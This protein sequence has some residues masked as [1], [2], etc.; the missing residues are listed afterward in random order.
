MNTLTQ[1]VVALTL[2]AIS[3]GAIAIFVYFRDKGKKLNQR[4]T[5][6]FLS[7]A[8]WSIGEAFAISAPTNAKGLLLWRINQIGVIFIPIF[9]V[10]FVFTLLEIKGKKYKL[11]PISYFIGGIFL[12]LDSTSLFVLEVVPKFSFNYFINPGR[13]YYLFIACWA[14]WVCYGLFELLRAHLVSSGAK[15][16]QL[17]YF[18]WSMLFA[19]IGGAPNFLPTFGIEIPILMP[20]GTYVIPIHALITAYAIIKYRLM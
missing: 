7:I 14:A 3:T 10:H 12:V 16:T 15:R 18:A 11:I 8:W 17:K 6:Y 9:F 2:T 19:Y 1:Y 5:L 4:F 13:F 20:F